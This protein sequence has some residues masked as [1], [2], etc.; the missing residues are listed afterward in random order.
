MP[1]SKPGRHGGRPC[2]F[3]LALA[4]VRHCQAGRAPR[5]C[6]PAGRDRAHDAQAL[7]SG[8]VGRPI[9]VSSPWSKRSTGHGGAANSPGRCDRLGRLGGRGS[10]P[11]LA[12][13]CQNWPSD[14]GGI[15][16]CFFAISEDIRLPEPGPQFWEG[17]THPALSITV[18]PFEPKAPVI[19]W[20]QGFSR[21]PHLVGRVKHAGL[22]S[23]ADAACF[24]RPTQREHRNAR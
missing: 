23:D 21:E 20:M 1:C 12:A 17:V 15:I 10:P 5:R 22:P 8:G 19:C 14:F 9:P 13:G 11:S 7:A 2:R 24:T 6:R 3:I 4:L 16:P 18:D